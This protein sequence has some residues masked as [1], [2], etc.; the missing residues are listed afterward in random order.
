MK[1]PNDAEYIDICVTHIVSSCVVYAK[2]VGTEYHEKLEAL[3]T[4]INNNFENASVK[5]AAN[6]QIGQYYIALYDDEWKR[7]QLTGMTDDEDC[8]I[9]LV[10]SGMKT[11]VSK[12]DVKNIQPKF[13]RLPFQVI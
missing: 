13:L 1:L 12:E 10:D 2:M 8:E 6:L 5:P 3:E 7:A 11:V 9:L 4:A